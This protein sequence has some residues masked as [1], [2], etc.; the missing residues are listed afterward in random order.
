MVNDGTS[1]IP[2]VYSRYVCLSSANTG[3]ER[4]HLLRENAQN[5]LPYKALKTGFRLETSFG[6]QGASL[7][8]ICKAWTQSRISPPP[9]P[10]GTTHLFLN[11][12]KRA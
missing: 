5:Q 8:L 10:L 3:Y 6:F 9:F 12:S 7:A 1:V 11:Q 2:M 4:V